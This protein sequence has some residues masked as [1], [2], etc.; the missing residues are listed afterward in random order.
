MRQS[1]DAKNVGA[2]S[3]LGAGDVGGINHLPLSTIAPE[4]IVKRDM[5]LCIQCGVCT[6]QCSYDAQ[7]IDAEDGKVSSD[8]ANCCGWCASV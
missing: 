5:D 3:S 2:A 8:C 1:S 7:K 4:F 6:R